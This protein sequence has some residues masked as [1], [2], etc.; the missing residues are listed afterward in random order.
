MDG[1]GNVVAFP[2]LYPPTKSIRSVRSL[3]ITDPNAL[4]PRAVYHG[5]EIGWAL[6]KFEKPPNT[7]PISIQFFVLRSIQEVKRDGFPLGRPVFGRRPAGQKVQDLGLLWLSSF[8]VRNFSIV[9]NRYQAST[10]KHTVVRPGLLGWISHGVVLWR[11]LA[12]GKRLLPLQNIRG[13]FL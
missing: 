2:F 3:L 6:H 10:R 11:L 4:P 8:E 12:F 9:W 5:F 7:P 13:Q 1:G